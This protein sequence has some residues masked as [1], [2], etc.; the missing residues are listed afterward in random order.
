MHQRGLTLIE[1]LATV[2]ILAILLHLAMPSFRQLINSN[3]QQVAAN[4][5]LNAVRSART[6]AVLRNQSVIIQPL[7]G[8]WA[9]GWRMIAD[10]S[11]KGLSDPENPVLAV[12]QSGGKVRI[13]GNYRL[14]KWVRF[15]GM[16]TPSYAGASPGNGTLFICDEGTGLTHSRVVINV[17]GR[18][19]LL[20]GPDNTEP[21]SVSQWS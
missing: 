10:V 1:L 13:V 11:G 20:A 2:T 15:N 9:F 8:D 6:E 5:L 21:C 4:E 18:V 7:E 17:P 12:R 16:G 3:R 14:E 19:Q